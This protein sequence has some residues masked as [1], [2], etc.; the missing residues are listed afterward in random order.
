M[1]DQEKILYFLRVTGPTLPGKVAKNLKTEILL[2]S[3]YLSDLAAQKK[4]R[5]S[6]LKVGGSPLYYLPGQEDQLVH[7]AAGNLN[8]K[9]YEVLEELKTKK[10]LRE[11]D[12]DLLHKVALRN[13]RDFAVPLQVAYQ[14]KTELFWKWYMLSAEEA[15]SF[16]GNLLEPAAREKII[17]EKIKI[18]LPIPILEEKKLET[19]PEPPVKLRQ[20]VL[21]ALSLQPSE[22]KIQKEPS[23]RGRKKSLQPDGLLEQV[24]DYFRQKEIEIDQKEI[25]RKNAELNLIAKV[26]SVFGTVTH[27]CKIKKK[28]LCDEKDLSSAYVEAQ[29]KKLPLLFLHTGALHQKAQDILDSK[30]LENVLVKKLE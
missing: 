26:P 16:I 22:E 23:K 18:D 8:Q 2:A 19:L 30:A 15:N 4:V 24:E 27:F 14:G 6:Y 17:E 12:V 9:D 11:S 20:E 1:L 21:E 28:R 29:V 13:L 10:I 25:I 5:I 7:F 3:A